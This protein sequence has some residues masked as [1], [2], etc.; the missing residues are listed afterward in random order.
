M[1]ISAYF[2]YYPLHP[3]MFFVGSHGDL[4]VYKIQFKQYYP[5]RHVMINA[6]FNF[7]T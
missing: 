3:K 1:R 4:S 5:Q 6:K 7:M 2:I